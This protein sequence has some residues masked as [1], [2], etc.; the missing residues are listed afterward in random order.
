M[1]DKNWHYSS[2]DLREEQCIST[3]LELYLAGEPDGGVDVTM[4]YTGG[5]FILR[6]TQ[7]QALDF[8]TK[9]G[10][11][12]MDIEQARLGAKPKLDSLAGAE[13]EKAVVNG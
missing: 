1:S 7:P 10:V 8:A 9:I 6:L 2:I 5:A 3:K 12:L 13:A 4:S 11:G